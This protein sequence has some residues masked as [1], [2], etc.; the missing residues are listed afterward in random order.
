M[1]IEF[2]EYMKVFGNETQMGIIAQI[3]T[4]GSLNLKLLSKMINKSESTTLGH[5]KKLVELKYLE[6]DKNESLGWGKFYKLTEK[7]LDAFKSINKVD[8]ILESS[9]KEEKKIYFLGISRLFQALASWPRNITYYAGIFM[10]EHIDEILNSDDKINLSDK[11]DLMIPPISINT[12]EEWLEYK[13]IMEDLKKNLEKFRNKK[14]P[15]THFL[16]IISVPIP[17]IHPIKE[18]RHNSIQ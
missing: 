10:E 4:F 7:P 1:A 16:S 8:E 9:T 17:D 6:I 11:V 13:G 12:E 15:N 2:E 14:T 18:K 5:V 3:I